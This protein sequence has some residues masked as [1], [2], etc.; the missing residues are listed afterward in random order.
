MNVHASIEHKIDDIKDRFYDELKHVFD[1]F[2]R[3]PMKILLA[4]FNAKVGRKRIHKTTTGNGS[5]NES[6]NDNGVRVVNF[7]KSK[8]L[9]KV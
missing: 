2:P 8:N 7:A 6:S 3:Y 1:I 9:S 5:L 4:D